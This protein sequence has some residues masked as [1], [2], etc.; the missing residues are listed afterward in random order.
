MSGTIWQ[1]EG[2]H[3]SAGWE[4]SI[5]VSAVTARYGGVLTNWGG[6]VRGVKEI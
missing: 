1:D 4:C 5:A 3:G 2:I 6:M